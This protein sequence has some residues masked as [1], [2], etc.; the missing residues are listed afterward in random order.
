MTQESACTL[1]INDLAARITRIKWQAG[2]TTW[3]R[4]FR[5]GNRDGTLQPHR[6]SYTYTE[7]LQSVPPLPEGWAERQN[8]QHEACSSQG[9]SAGLRRHGGLTVHHSLAKVKWPG[10][11]STHQASLTQGPR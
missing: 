8:G 1:H 9:L 7:G 6:A 4:V 2:R 10:K 11:E 3:R 5:F